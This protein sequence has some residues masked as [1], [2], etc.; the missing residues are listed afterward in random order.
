M[1]LLLFQ[2]KQNT[3]TPTYILFHCFLFISLH[4]SFFYCHRSQTWTYQLIFFCNPLRNMSQQVPLQWS[5]LQ[6]TTYPVRP[7][8]GS[9]LLTGLF[10][11]GIVCPLLSK[12]FFLLQ[13]SKQTLMYWSFDGVV[14]SSL[15]DRFSD[16]TEFLQSMH[17]LLRNLQSRRVLTPRKN[18]LQCFNNLALDTVSLTIKMLLDKQRS[19]GNKEHS[20][21]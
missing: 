7:L 21:I 10:L 20:R 6:T 13:W 16:K 3:S 14:T 12:S 9:L 19:A 5:G 17:C 11:I 2:C 18:T 1:L 4:P 15:S 8:S